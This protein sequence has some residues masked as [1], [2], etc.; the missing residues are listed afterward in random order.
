[1]PSKD[2]DGTPLMI[3]GEGQPLTLVIGDTSYRG[4][5]QRRSDTEQWF[6]KLDGGGEIEIHKREEPQPVPE[7]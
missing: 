4:T 3:L 1:M 5:L 2:F 6:V 7:A